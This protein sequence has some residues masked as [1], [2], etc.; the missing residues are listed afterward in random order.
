VLGVFDS[1]LA[2]KCDGTGLGLPLAKRLIELLGG[3]LKIESAI[4]AGTTVTVSLP[5]DRLCPERQ[6]A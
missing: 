3:T 5:P 1:A 4:G 6:A 2:R